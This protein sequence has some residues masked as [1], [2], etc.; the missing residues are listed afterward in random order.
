V[1][2]LDLYAFL[3]KGDKTADVRLQDGDVIFYPQAAGHMAF[4]GKV[5]APGV[6]EIKNSQETV[7]DFLSLAGGLPV[8]ADPRR[9][10]IERLTPGKDQPRRVEDLTLDEAGLKKQIQNG[11]VV[12]LT[13]TKK[14]YFLYF[15]FI[16]L[17]RFTLV[18]IRNSAVCLFSKK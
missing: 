4:V 14:F 17:I 7:A 2:E 18:L 15:L 6:F 16:L 9:A 5:N 12:W 8:V 1:S 10:N 3:G 11:D 13:K